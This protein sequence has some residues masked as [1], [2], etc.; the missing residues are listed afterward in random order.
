MRERLTKSYIKKQRTKLANYQ[1]KL[2][3]ELSLIGKK[4]EGYRPSFPQ[5]GSTEED[6]IL[7]M[8][9]FAENLS[10]EE[11]LNQLLKETKQAIRRIDRNRY[12][13]CRQ[14]QKLIQ[15]ERLDIYPLAVDC[16]S[17]ARKKPG[18]LL[19]RFWPFRK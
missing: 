1:K 19:G 9:D 10:I 4:E 15:K 5:Y 6:N 13:I 2:E 17:C 16:I 14:C 12:G 3:T 7:E 11:K 18:G 8:E